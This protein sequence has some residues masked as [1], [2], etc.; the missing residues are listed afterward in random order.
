MQNFGLFA[1]GALTVALGGCALIA[2][3]DFG[4]WG[5]DLR[6]AGAGGV[7]GT[8]TA[9][10]GGPS[11]SSNS[12]A[13]SSTSTSTSSGACTHGVIAGQAAGVLTAPGVEVVSVAVDDQYVFWTESVSPNVVA[14][15][16]RVDKGGISVMDQVQSGQTQARGLVLD[17]TAAYWITTAAPPATGDAIWRV[18]K[19]FA[20]PMT[21]ISSSNMG[22]YG[23]LAVENG[24]VYFSSAAS[25][26]SFGSAGIYALSA[27]GGAPQQVIALPN[28]LPTDVAADATSVYFVV[29][30]KPGVTTM[31]VRRFDLTTLTTTILAANEPGVQGLVT[32]GVYV[33]WSTT[34]GLHKAPKAGAVLQSIGTTAMSP[35]GGMSADASYF[36]CTA[37]NAGTVLQIQLGAMNPISVGPAIASPMRGIAAD[38][39]TVYVAAGQQIDKIPRL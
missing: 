16:R 35:C 4:K 22:S 23:G 20:G 34:G 18:L 1:V 21:P 17:A 27:G 10:G 33:Y 30:T 7:G 39:S 2:N 24:V 19:S 31:D 13:S 3:Y 5:Q 29:E 8:G 15:L 25:G 26:T 14:K 9:S 6:D 32:D 11:T 37:N 12:S 36:Y 28:E 38:C